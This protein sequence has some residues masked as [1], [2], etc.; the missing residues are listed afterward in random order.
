MPNYH[1]NGFGTWKCAFLF[2]TRLIFC[3][4]PKRFGFFC[5]EIDES[6]CPAMRGGEDSF[7]GGLVTQGGARKASS[8][9]RQKSHATPAYA[10]LSSVSPLGNEKPD[11]AQTTF[12]LL[13]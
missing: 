3:R 5:S 4:V 8:R 6:P 12:R 9:K 1:I 7:L 10:G 13:W 2:S 11:V